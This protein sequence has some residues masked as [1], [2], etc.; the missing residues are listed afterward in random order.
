[1][2]RAFPRQPQQIPDAAGVRRMFDGYDTG[3]RMADDLVGALLSQL[4]DLGV[5]GAD[6]D[7]TAIMVSSDHGEALGELNVYGDHQ[8][9]DQVTTRVPMILRW[10]GLPAGTRHEAL[11]Y[12]FDVN[13]TILE[14]L[15]QP[16][17][18]RWHGTGRAESWRSGADAGR[19][20]LV[21]SQAA[22]ACQRGVRFDDWLYLR[23]RHDAFHLWPDVMV[24]DVAG[25]PHQ[26]HDLSEARPDLVARGADL[27]QAWRD[28]PAPRRRPGPRPPRQRDGRGRAVPR[29]RRGCRPTPSGCGRPDAGPRPT[30]WPPAGATS[31]RR[32]ARRRRLACRHARVD[33]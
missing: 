6:E 10:P 32:V 3:V 13:A 19:D 29:A 28:R 22:W 5:D 9:A 26:Q 30:T 33:R 27:L 23:T 14:L 21:V 24:F 15:G 12:Q 20:H 25:D 8:A 17:P 2:A 1:M 4:A 16:V 11:H 18:S 31:R 7:G